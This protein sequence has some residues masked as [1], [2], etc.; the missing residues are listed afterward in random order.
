[1][2]KLAMITLLN[3]KTLL[4]NSLIIFLS[5]KLSFVL[6]QK[7]IL[8]FSLIEAL[9]KFKKVVPISLLKIVVVIT[10]RLLTFCLSNTVQ[11]KKLPR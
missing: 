2:L 1:M 7:T 3:Q 4:D 6:R 11:L 5:D 10:A 8:D 9:G